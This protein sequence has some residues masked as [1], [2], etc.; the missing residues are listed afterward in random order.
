LDHL[1]H[2]ALEKTYIVHTE[3]AAKEY[4]VD[5]MY[6]YLRCYGNCR[7]HYYLSAFLYNM[8]KFNKIL[9]YIVIN[10]VLCRPIFMNIISYAERLYTSSCTENGRRR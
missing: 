10:L 7:I 3:E 5:E 1:A 2:G 9:V 8:G 6:S 4:I